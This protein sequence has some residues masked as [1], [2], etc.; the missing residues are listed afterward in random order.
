MH[1]N[2]FMP[3]TVYKRFSTQNVWLKSFAN[4]SSL[5]RLMICLQFISYESDFGAQWEI[6]FRFLWMALSECELGFSNLQHVS[7]KQPVRLNW[8]PPKL[9]LLHWKESVQHSVFNTLFNTP[10]SVLFA[11][12]QFLMH[13]ITSNRLIIFLPWRFFDWTREPLFVY[14]KCCRSLVT[15]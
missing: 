10:F 7:Y 4:E 9:N 8:K 5:I 2:D 12:K 3:R 1:T 11:L 6:V 14:S 13:L 15:K